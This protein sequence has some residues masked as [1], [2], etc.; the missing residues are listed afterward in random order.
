[1][2][3][4]WFIVLSIAAFACLAFVARAA[5]TAVMADNL[6]DSE[7]DL[8]LRRLMPQLVHRPREGTDWVQ[9]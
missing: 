2:S 3:N 6:L 9:N 5:G 1:M 8:E 4:G 7:D